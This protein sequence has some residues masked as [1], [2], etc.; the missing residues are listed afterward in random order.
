MASRERGV[1]GESD[2]HAEEQALQ[3]RIMALQKLGN[4]DQDMFRPSFA[5]H[6]KIGFF[7]Q[8]R[9]VQTENTE[10]VEVKELTEVVQSLLQDT[11]DLKR[12]LRFTRHSLQSDYESKVQQKA[13]DLYCRINDNV[14]D[15]EKIHEDRVNVIR[16]AFRQQ[17][18][19]ALIRV[20]QTHAK[21][22]KNK[23]QSANKRHGDDAGKFEEKYVELLAQLQ[24]NESTIAMLE[25]QIDQL[26]DQGDPGPSE[27]EEAL[28]QELEDISLKAKKMQK[29]ID[30][31][32]EALEIKEDEIQQKTAELTSLTDKF[33]KEAA[34]AMKLRQENEEMKDS[35]EQDKAT[36]KRQ[37]QFSLP[38]PSPDNVSVSSYENLGPEQQ[39]A[40]NDKLMEG[41]R[42]AHE[43]ELDEKMKSMKDEIIATA[44]RET[45]MLLQDERERYTRLMEQKRALDET[46]A[47]ERAANAEKSLEML[48]M[49]KMRRSELRLQAEVL[50]LKRE[51]D[52]V[53][54][55]W[56]KKFAILQQS[57]HALKDESFLRQTLQRQ[58]AQLHQ[59]S[60]TYATD[61]PLGIL[62]A[63]NKHSSTS[64]PRKP[65]PNIP[66]KSTAEKDY[67]S[68][69]VS[70]PSGRGTGLFSL[71][72][73]QVMSDDNEEDIPEG[74]VPLPT[75]PTRTMTE[76]GEV[77]SRPSTS[78]KSHVVVLPSVHAQ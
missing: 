46:L 13:I 74:T 38:Q 71:D 73:N 64:V 36:Q 49:E 65:L 48:D 54:R 24:R 22:L 25:A 50:R 43:K 35:I 59:A 68:Y 40:E 75:P 31:L 10:I 55:T 34:L 66:P 58:A 62:P 39:E 41:Q 7:S 63:A 18:A 28:T 20:N 9:N 67:M 16:R 60:I 57:L 29:K 37:V 3:G 4:E 2:Y 26:Q 72:E 61:T 17:L 5:D 51:I 19:D 30:R 56:E 11:Q 14:A 78:S 77:A 45:E 8:D 47:K 44:N 76:C 21:V 32:E 1:Q 52:K 53:N 33:E 70:A 69:T 6:P 12:D 15:L 27:A 23:L 42:L